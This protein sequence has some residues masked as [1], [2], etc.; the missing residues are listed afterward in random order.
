MTKITQLYRDRKLKVTGNSVT[1]TE[2]GEIFD[3]AK[4]NLMKRTSTGDISISSTE[5]VYLDTEILGELLA[6]NKIKQ[7]DLALLIS[8][9]QNLLI[10]HNICMVDDDNPHKTST[11]AKL[12]NCTEQAV[13][14]KLNRLVNL[15][16][17]YYGF[18]TTKKHLGK[19]YIMNP[20]FIRKGRKL[21]GYLR[22]LFDN[23]L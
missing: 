10:N 22:T 4:S 21:A 19:V 12:T 13:K 9:S 15:G 14:I 20:H 2:T 1:D 6:K 8:L 5:Y 3:V 7:V 11:I 23:P 17:L 16:L 18:I